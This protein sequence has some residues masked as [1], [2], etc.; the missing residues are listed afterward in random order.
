M[1]NE[2]QLRVWEILDFRKKK[3]KRENV[4][5]CFSSITVQGHNM[6]SQAKRRGVRGQA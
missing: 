5:H 3:L 2:E 4:A 6:H 1:Y